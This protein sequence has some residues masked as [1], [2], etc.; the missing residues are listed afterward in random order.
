MTQLKHK[1][2]L[3]EELKDKDSIKDALLPIVYSYKER[4][5]TVFTNGNKNEQEL[6]DKLRK[7]KEYSLNNIDEL[8][9]TAIKN[10]EKNGVKI[11]EAKTIADAERDIKK[12]IGQEKLIVKSKSNTA[13]EINLKEML[14][15]KEV[16]ETDLGDF[17]IENLDAEDL[18][19]VLPAMHLTPERI[20]SSL[21]KKFNQDIKPTPEAI[22]E[23]AREK[24]RHKIQNA[25]IGI[26]GANVISAD[27]SIFILENEGNVS[28]VSRIP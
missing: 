22:A 6:K 18:H 2:S 19:P 24:I 28:L 7:I 17:I 23:F 20:S 16:I 11:L 13:N 4:R 15:D 1:K 3:I 8:K 12:I 10:L 27:G 21:S 5:E 25:K 26:T 9:K 14:K